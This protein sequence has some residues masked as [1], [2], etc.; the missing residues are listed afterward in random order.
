MLPSDSLLLKN[1]NPNIVLLVIDC[2]RPDRFSTYGHYRPTTPN[3]DKLAANGVQ[4]DNAYTVDTASPLSH[5]AL[6]SGQ[7]DWAGRAWL[8][9]ASLGSKTTFFF[10]RILRRLGLSKNMGGYDPKQHSL[11]KMLKENGYYSLGLSANQLVSPQTLKAYAGFD[12]FPEDELFAGLDSNPEIKKKL[13]SYGVV[14]S[15]ANRQAVYLTAD[16]IMGMVKEKIE[17]GNPGMQ[18]PFF[19]FMN[20]MDCHDPYLVNEQ[21]KED[22][23]FI[24]N[25]KFNSDLR[26]R[27]EVKSGKGEETEHWTNTKDL[28]AATVD[29]LRWKYDRCLGFID[30]QVGKMVRWL[31]DKGQMENTIFFVLSDHAEQLGEHGYFTH[32]MAPSEEQMH[33]P[34]IVSGESFVKAGQRRNEAVSIV[35]VRP[36]IFDLLGVKD[37]FKH[38]SGQSLFNGNRKVRSA[39]TWQ[40]QRSVNERSSKLMGEDRVEVSDNELQVMEA[41]LRDLGY[42]D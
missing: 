24:P 32:S 7:R 6:M 38:R 33:I 42:M 39:R 40:N 35:D 27:S 9:N 37:N 8:Q 25:S 20:V 5:F 23:G 41:R 26:N 10:R 22:F 36:T 18:K 1:G 13:K 31:K 4:F 30:G 19:L 28:D 34:M 17:K 11:L 21:Y 15:K 2:G 16:R 12:S 14:D 3:I 29:L